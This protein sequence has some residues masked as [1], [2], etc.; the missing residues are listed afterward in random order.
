MPATRRRGHPV[1]P[2]V[3]RNRSVP[4]FRSRRGGDAPVA[5][6]GD[7][8]GGLGDLRHESPLHPAR[9]PPLLRCAR[10][11]PGRDHRGDGSRPARR[12]AG[13]H[14]G[15]AATPRRSSFRTG[16][17]RRGRRTSRGPPWGDRSSGS[18]GGSP[19]WSVRS[20]AAGCGRR[21][22]SRRGAPAGSRARRRRWSRR[23]RPRTPPSGRSRQGSRTAPSCSGSTGP[24]GSRRS[25]GSPARSI[26]RGGGGPPR[27][28][29]SRT[30]SSRSERGYVGEVAVTART[31]SPIA[32]FAAW[33]RN[34]LS[35]PPLKA[36]TADPIR[37]S[38]ASNAS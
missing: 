17:A 25:R 7:R 24:A 34:E 33:R 35:T 28:G 15:A 9:A 11:R 6:G 31:R 20:R 13:R 12:H 10:T 30:A 29:A 23:T 1:R 21:A 18:G 37:R 8:A 3:H 2:V 38:A 36:I 5:S 27:N 22:P 14:P 19:A 26:R 4:T 16:S 32:S